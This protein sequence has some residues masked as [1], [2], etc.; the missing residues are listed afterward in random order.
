MGNR[1]FCR[2]HVE[3]EI[4]F[5]IFSAN[6]VK[7]IIENKSYRIQA[8]A[9]S[10]VGSVGVRTVHRHHSSLTICI[11][12][13]DKNLLACSRYAAV[14]ILMSININFAIF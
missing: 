6:A 11:N 12:T 10:R 5:T 7:N 9:F 3:D 8:A 2:E 14:W 1:G 4:Y 13:W